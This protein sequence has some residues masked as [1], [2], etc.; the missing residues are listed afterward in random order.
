MK[1]PNRRGLTPTIIT[2]LI[3]ILVLHV[4]ARTLKTVLLL[5]E[6]LISTKYLT[7]TFL[8]GF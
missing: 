2:H 3:R 7:L 8:D 4:M 1:A 6:R 5:F